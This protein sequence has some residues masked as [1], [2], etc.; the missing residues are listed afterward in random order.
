MLPFGMTEKFV[1]EADFHAVVNSWW[2]ESVKYGSV[3]IDC[4]KYMHQYS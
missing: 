4:L 2:T 1:I 3:A